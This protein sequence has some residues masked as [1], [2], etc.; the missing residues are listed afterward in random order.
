MNKKKDKIILIVVAILVGMTLYFV[1]VKNSYFSLITEQFS[2]PKW[3]EISERNI[4]KNAI[5][6]TLIEQNDGKCK[7]TAHDFDIIVDHAYFKRGE[8]LAKKLSYDRES[9]TLILPCETLKGEKSRLNVWYVVEES[10][11]YSTK[12]QYFVTPW[13]DTSSQ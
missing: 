7:V 5:P 11:K 10:P 6:V 8:E 13:N 4:V 1:P 9:Q 2:E 12:Y 3:D